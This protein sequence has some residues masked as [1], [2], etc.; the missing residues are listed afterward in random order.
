MKPLTAVPFL[1]VV[2]LAACLD[3]PEPVAFSLDTDRDAAST[4]EDLSS[5]DTEPDTTASPDTPSGDASDASTDAA[6]DTTPAPT[7]VTPETVDP[8]AALVPGYAAIAVQEGEEVLPQTELHLSVTGFPVHCIAAYRWE[9]D[10]PIGSQSLLMP[11]SSA[12]NPSVEINVAG[13]FT[14]RVELTGHDGQRLA[15]PTKQ[16]FVNPGAGIHIELLWTTPGD[17]DPHDLQG[18]DLDLH[19][20]LGGA[21]GDYDGDGDGQFDPWYD[22]PFDT[23]WYNNAPD[24]GSLDPGIDDNPS[25]DRDDTDGIGPE[26]LNLQRPEDGKTYRVGVHYFSDHGLGPSFATVRI[27]IHGNLVFE[28]SDVELREFDFWW[29]TEFTWPPQADTV[30][31]A[32][33]TCQGTTDRCTTDLDCTTTCTLRITP[34]YHHPFFASAP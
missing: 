12:P 22:I 16:V 20:A 32:S 33:R 23:Y 11:S 4:D 6:P 21:R 1:S 7:D 28:Q 19:F 17:A 30:P 5:L 2:L 3:H 9:L 27:Y 14:F 26:N 34:N 10:Q 8:C 31:T 29:V 24:W 18:T 25:L 15:F 13:T